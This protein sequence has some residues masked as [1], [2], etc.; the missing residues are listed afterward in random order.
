MHVNS[1]IQILITLRLHICNNIRDM[2]TF[3]GMILIKQRMQLAKSV[4]VQSCGVG[5]FAAHEVAH[6]P[7]QQ[8]MLDRWS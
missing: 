2:N 8:H 7:Y 3:C 5:S 4:H 6:V 1:Q